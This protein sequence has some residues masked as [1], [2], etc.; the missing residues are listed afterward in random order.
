MDKIW[1]KDLP[2]SGW[3]NGMGLVRLFLA[4]VVAG[5][6]FMIRFAIPQGVSQ[7]GVDQWVFFNGGLAVFFFY[8]ISGFLISCPLAKVWRGPCRRGAVL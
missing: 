3:G 8:V 4:L 1:L 2:G 6:H 5:D 7:R